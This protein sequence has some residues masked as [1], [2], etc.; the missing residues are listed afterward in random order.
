VSVENSS[1][2]TFEN[3]RLK[4]VAGDIHRVEKPEEMYDCRLTWLTL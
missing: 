2:E 3:A 4:L 1:G